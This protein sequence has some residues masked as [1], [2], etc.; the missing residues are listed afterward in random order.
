MLVLRRKIWYTVSVKH[1]GIVRVSVPC[2]GQVRTARLMYF[3]AG[4]IAPRRSAAR[5]QG[6]AHILTE[7]R[8]GIKNCIWICLP[9]SKR[10]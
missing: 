5:G 2:G 6:A 10:T 7:N 1:G 8:G 4:G 3:A 9:R